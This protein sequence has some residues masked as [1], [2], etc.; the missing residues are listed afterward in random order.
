[1]HF[2]VCLGWAGLTDSKR[3]G[4][5]AGG[6]EHTDAGRKEKPKSQQVTTPRRGTKEGPAERLE[7]STGRRRDLCRGA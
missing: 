2:N 1:M 6:G 7:N 3:V 4:A 5:G